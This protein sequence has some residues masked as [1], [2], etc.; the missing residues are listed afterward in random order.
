MPLAD[1]G[2]DRLRGAGVVGRSTLAAGCLGQPRP[3]DRCRPARRGGF[4]RPLRRPPARCS[5]RSTRP[6]NRTQRGVQRPR[7]RITSP[8]RSV[9]RTTGRKRSSSL[10]LQAAG[11]DQGVDQ[12]DR[13]PAAS[14]APQ[15]ERAERF[16][17]SFVI[18]AEPE[19][20]SIWAIRFL[21]QG[22]R[23]SVRA[24]PLS[25]IRTASITAASIVA[26]AGTAVD[27]LAGGAALRPRA[28]GGSCRN[29][30]SAAAPPRRSSA[31]SPAA[32][33][34]RS[35]RSGSPG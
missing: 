15:S 29:G 4:G 10:L 19:P 2:D 1:G 34:R 6:G 22:K 27:R 9:N 14:S 31:G 20:Q 28:A 21:P 3:R 7:P 11:R 8:P 17:R 33:T 13:P 23:A 12:R 24:T 26:P 25:T 32:G 35:G 5:F 30:R 16:S 18:L